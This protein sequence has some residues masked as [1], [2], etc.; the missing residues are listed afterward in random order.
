[1]R[2]VPEWIGATPDTAIP[3]RVRLRVFERCDSRCHRCNR[4]LTPADTW[5]VEHM[6]A[7]VNGGA[8]AESNLSITCG[9]CKPVKDA[10]DVAIKSKSARVR[11]KHAGI[12]PKRSSFAT[13]KNGRFKAKI[14]GGIELR[15]PRVPYT[16]SVSNTNTGDRDGE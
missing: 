7:L 8:N 10:E 3:P 16:A 1:M 5:I 13:N 4:K 2:S 15:E 14:G 9:W 11:A 6:T 12:K